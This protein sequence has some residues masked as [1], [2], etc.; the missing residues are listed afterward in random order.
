M[1]SVNKKESP[2]TE[3]QERLEYALGEKSV[4][5]GD[6]SE[7][8]GDERLRSTLA[9]VRLRELRGFTPLKELLTFH[10]NSSTN[11]ERYTVDIE[12]LDLS[13]DVY[14]ATILEFAGSPI[15]MD[16]HMMRVPYHAIKW[17]PVFKRHESGEETEDYKIAYSWGR[18]AYHYK[19]N[20]EFLTIRRPHNHTRADENLVIVRHWYEKVPL[21]K[22]HIITQIQVQPLPFENFRK[23]FGSSHAHMAVKV[24]SELTSIYR[25]TVSELEN[26]AGSLRKKTVE[27]EKLSEALSY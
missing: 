14:L 4:R 12:T 10:P 13:P 8:E 26:E 27:L 3:A 17:V 22:R 2:K 20:A 1:A 25:R 5:F 16:T 18:S 7:T 19:G 21:E 11:M 24:I 15:N 23:Y 6:L 9:D